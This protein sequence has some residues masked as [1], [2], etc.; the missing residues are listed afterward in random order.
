MILSRQRRRDGPG[1]WVEPLE[2]LAAEPFPSA[3][4]VWICSFGPDWNRFA[5]H[6]FTG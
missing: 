5:L 3:D 6:R 4:L 2:R 1:R